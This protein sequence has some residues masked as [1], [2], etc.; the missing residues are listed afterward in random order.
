MEH[1]SQRGWI[2]FTDFVGAK[3]QLSFGVDQHVGRL[4]DGGLAA[5]KQ[6]AAEL[7]NYRNRLSWLERELIREQLGS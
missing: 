2:G 6:R 3:R 5:P 1:P 7:G 4:R